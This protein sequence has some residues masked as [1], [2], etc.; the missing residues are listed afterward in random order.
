MSSNNNTAELFTFTI[1][2]TDDDD[3]RNGPC[4]NG[5]TCVDGP[6]SFTCTCAPGFTGNTCAVRELNISS[7]LFF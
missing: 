6:S 2:L 1:F 7:L 5:G 4:L 3:C